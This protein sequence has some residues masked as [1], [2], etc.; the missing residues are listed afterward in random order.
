MQGNVIYWKGFVFVVWPVDVEVLV[1]WTEQIIRKMV[2]RVQCNIEIRLL[3]T[4][5]KEV[6]EVWDIYND[7]FWFWLFEVIYWYDFY[8]DYLAGCEFRKPSWGDILIV[9]DGF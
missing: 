2:S 6:A 1:D 8:F 9:D 5:A 7:K 4:M 3:S